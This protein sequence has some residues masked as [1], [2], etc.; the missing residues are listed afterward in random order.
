M[1][2]HRRELLAASPEASRFWGGPHSYLCIHACLDYD[3]LLEFSLGTL[4]GR[5]VAT[6][7]HFS[8]LEAE[9]RVSR[10]SGYPASRKRVVEDG[11]SLKLVHKMHAIVFLRCMLLLLATD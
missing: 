1:R 11:G 4:V 10:T 2:S 7:V 5:L 8:V 3:S 6:P 9:A